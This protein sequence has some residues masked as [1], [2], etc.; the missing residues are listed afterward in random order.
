M[1]Y[2]KENSGSKNKFVF[3]PKDDLLSHEEYLSKNQNFWL[4]YWVK[5]PDIIRIL[6]CFIIGLFIF[7]VLIIVKI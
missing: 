1:I 7:I 3:N 2:A 4:K 5:D 6:N